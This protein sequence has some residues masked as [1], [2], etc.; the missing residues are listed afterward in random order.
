M[1]NV[2]I[3]SEAVANAMKMMESSSIE[4]MAEEFA[5]FLNAKKG[6]HI[7]P[8][9]VPKEKRDP[10]DIEID[11]KLKKEILRL[12][13]EDIQNRG[14]SQKLDQFMAQHYSP[15]DKYQEYADFKRRY[16]SRVFV[17][18]IA[19]DL[20]G[21]TK[22][23]GAKVIQV[24]KGIIDKLCDVK[25]KGEDNKIRVNALDTFIELFQSFLKVLDDTRVKNFLGLKNLDEV[26]RGAKREIQSLKEK[27]KAKSKK[28]SKTPE[29]LDESAVQDIV[30]LQ[31]NLKGVRD[32][33]K[34]GRQRSA[35]A[36]RKRASAA[37]QPS[38]P[39]ARQDKTG[40][41]PKSHIFDR[42]Q[43]EEL[44][45]ASRRVHGLS[46]DEVSDDRLDNEKQSARALEMDRSNLNRPF[47]EEYPEAPHR[48]PAPDA[49]MSDLLHDPV[50]GKGRQG[51][52]EEKV[53]A[54]AAK[55]PRRDEDLRNV[56]PLKGEESQREQTAQIHRLLR[57]KREQEIEL[58]KLRGQVARFE[59][60]QKRKGKGPQ[61]PGPKPPVAETKRDIELA[62]LREQVRNLEGALRQ[63]PEDGIPHR[64]HQ[65]L[66]AEY[67]MEVE[68][69]KQAEKDALAWKQFAEQQANAE[70]G[71]GNVLNEKL[72]ALQRD[73]D[74]LDERAAEFRDE[75]D[76]LKDANDAL[77]EKIEERDQE[78]DEIRGQLE[79]AER[80]RNE[81]SDENARLEAE[82]RVVQKT[83]A[84]LYDQ[85]KDSRDENHRLGQEVRE[86]EEN[87][88]AFQAENARNKEE[89][90]RL[91]A[92]LE[93]ANQEH[94]GLADELE[95]VAQER[96]GFKDRVGQLEHAYEELRRAYAEL[97][98][99]QQATEEHNR[100][101]TAEL[102]ASKLRE[103]AYLHALKVE[104][105]ANG[106][107]RR[108]LTAVERGRD[109][110]LT[111]LRAEEERNRRLQA[112]LDTDH[113]ARVDAQTQLVDEQR[114]HH[115][116]DA[117]RRRLD[118]ALIAEQRA[119]VATRGERDDAR[120]VLAA[121]QH[122]HGVTR[123]ERDAHRRERDAARVERD[124]FRGER[125]AARGERAVF[126]RERN[127]ARAALGAA[128]DE[129]QRYKDLRTLSLGGHGPMPTL[130]P[131]AKPRR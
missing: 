77:G 9:N 86:L 25:L 21:E 115:A 40:S 57:E 88:Q 109:E 11:N 72:E 49:G 74:E 122:A 125:D 3:L 35:E 10:K 47:N 78:I 128:G 13:K 33:A 124:A 103:K 90:E 84:E 63:G 55:Q 37:N 79:A 71:Q 64:Q 105:N 89:N 54:E 30:S 31:E 62:Q 68:R 120:R 59:E 131:N 104:R 95:T 36:A 130:P 26:L 22:K 119:H 96:D 17:T 43:L 100:Q 39:Q 27:L 82:N 83:N 42:K 129:L 67:Q 102:H 56:E 126:E 97:E 116:T 34:E 99:A 93:T 48:G 44:A 53:E 80:A 19:K 75:N 46:P 94:K 118:A 70:Q 117:E 58:A 1:E 16:Q 92:E 111:Q 41:R 66:I 61:Q 45:E 60:A 127:E 101:L 15:Y 85:Y 65:Q 23:K 32:A 123:A 114:R 98:R 5:Y 113:K 50:S 110:A 12:A 91:H 7:T 2:K 29:A 108:G 14:K 51:G 107:L 38:S 112:T 4:D 87:N 8:I 28:G 20:L 106:E 76:R 6:R 24:R 52:A 18:S 121:E 69:R 73:F 81:F